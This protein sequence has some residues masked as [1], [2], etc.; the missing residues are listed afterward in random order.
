[1]KDFMSSSGF[2]FPVLWNL[3]TMLGL[4][5]CQPLA[6]CMG[7]VRS[8]PTDQ[9]DD[10]PI[11]AYLVALLL[12]WLA[13]V[14]MNAAYRFLPGSLLQMLR[15]SKVAFVGILSHQ[16]LGKDLPKSRVAGI[17]LAIL[18][19]IIIGYGASHTIPGT[20]DVAV[21]WKYVGLALGSEFIRSMLYVYQETTMKKY[22]IPAWKLASTV[23][24]LALPLSVAA[25]VITTATGHE[26]AWL[27]WKML[28]QSALLGVTLGGFDLAT[29]IYEC[30]SMAITQHGSAMLRAMMELIRAALVWIAEVFLNLDL[31]T[32]LQSTGF[33]VM[34][35]G[36]LLDQGLM[37]I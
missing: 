31:P 37:K 12:H 1:M 32:A 22:K 5:I 17:T 27:A 4:A 33:V 36:F 34:S 13:N 14:M 35:L 23:G 25:L 19:V 24:L 15:V 21:T 8:E 20:A 2:N 10:A 28:Q 3:A 7:Q 11:T 9:R 29:G 16:I 26:S 30:M 18:G 6:W